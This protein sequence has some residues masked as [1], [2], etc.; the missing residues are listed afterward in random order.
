MAQWDTN[1]VVVNG[2]IYRINQKIVDEIIQFNSIPFKGFELI[3]DDDDYATLKE[4]LKSHCF[5]YKDHCISIIQWDG[6]L[7]IEV[8]LPVSNCDWSIAAFQYVIDLCAYCSNGLLSSGHP[9]PVHDSALPNNGKG[10]L[11][12]EI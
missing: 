3:P 10:A 7:L 9:Y 1:E 8:P 2:K 6:R 5:V 4:Y 12:L 11:Y